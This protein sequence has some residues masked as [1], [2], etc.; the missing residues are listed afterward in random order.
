MPAV[1]REQGRMR[2]WCPTK[3][4]TP[5]PEV[6]LAR[7][8]R[9]STQMTSLQPVGDGTSRVSSHPHNYG[10]NLSWASFFLGGPSADLAPSSGGVPVGVGPNVGMKMKE[11]VEDSSETLWQPPSDPR[12]RITWAI[13]LPL[14]A[15]AHYTMPNCRLDKWKNWFLASFFLSMLWISIFS[16]V[17]VWM[18]TI[19]GMPALMYYYLQGLTLRNSIGVSTAGGGRIDSAPAL[20]VVRAFSCGFC[21]MPLELCRNSS[22]EMSRKFG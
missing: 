22:F 19:I 13:C 20:L 12:E 11:G 14:K 17:M 15:S 9:N 16:Y 2:H 6:S 18:I 1:C 21:V 8:Q 10:S 7:L 3:T 5:R 4:W